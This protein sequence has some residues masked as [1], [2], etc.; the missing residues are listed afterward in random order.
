MEEI[1]IEERDIAGV[2]IEV[3]GAV[4]QAVLA[5][6]LL[7]VSRALDQVLAEVASAAVGHGV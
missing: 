7:K 1:H 6:E 3:E 4:G 5:G 2:G